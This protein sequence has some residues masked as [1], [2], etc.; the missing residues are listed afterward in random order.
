[1]HAKIM[2]ATPYKTENLNKFLE[3]GLLLND[4]IH[5]PGA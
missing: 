1:M 4:G 3:V 5:R 2:A